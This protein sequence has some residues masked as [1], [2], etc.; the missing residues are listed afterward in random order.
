[1]RLPA[2][3]RDRKCFKPCSL[4]HQSDTQAMGSVVNDVRQTPLVGIYRCL[5]SEC[6]LDN[7]WMDPTG[8]DG[9]E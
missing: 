6:E 5:D 9:E 1:M 8:C 4:R 2:T 3:S 7:E